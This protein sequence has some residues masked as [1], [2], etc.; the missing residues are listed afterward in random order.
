MKRVMLTIPKVWSRVSW[1]RKE[2]TIP[3]VEIRRTIIGE[4]MYN[5]RASAFLD[6]T[7]ALSWMKYQKGA[8]VS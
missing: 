5:A 4:I 7:V 1:K 2:P 6:C 8:V 3:Q